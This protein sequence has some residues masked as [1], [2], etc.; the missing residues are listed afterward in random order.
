[1]ELKYDKAENLLTT[2]FGSPLQH[3]GVMLRLCGEGF[4]LNKLREVVKV[5][6]P[7]SL[8]MSA[9]ENYGMIELRVRVALIVE[10]GRSDADLIQRCEEV[11]NTTCVANRKVYDLRGVM[12]LQAEAPAIKSISPYLPGHGFYNQPISGNPTPTLV[13]VRWSALSK[14][15]LEM[16][17]V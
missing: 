9:I 1:M 6:M 15:I 17:L 12:T 7:N 10:R 5:L 3:K 11:L 8:W 2:V 16:A 4:L 13:T 14:D